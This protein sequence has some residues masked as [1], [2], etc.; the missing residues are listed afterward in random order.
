MEVT[1][2]S[3]SFCKPKP[4]RSLWRR[5]VVRSPSMDPSGQVVRHVC[6]VVSKGVGE[7]AHVVHGAFEVVDVS[8]HGVGHILSYNILW[9]LLL[10]IHSKFFFVHLLWFGHLLIECFISF[11]CNIMQSSLL[12]QEAVMHGNGKQVSHSRD[13]NEMRTMA[14]DYHPHTQKNTNINKVITCERA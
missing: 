5:L 1:S 7:V 14:G 6:S 10:I 8:V 3:L 4:V 12:N 2:P 13:L 9:L 11:L